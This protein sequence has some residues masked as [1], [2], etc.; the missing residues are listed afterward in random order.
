MVRFRYPMPVRTG[1]AVSAA[2][3][4][5]L[6]AFPQPVD[7]QETEQ[8]ILQELR[9]IRRLLEENLQRGRTAVPQ[10]PSRVEKLEG[11]SV[12]IHGNRFKGS[13]SARVTIV[14]FSDYQCPFCA[15]H[16]KET[17][18]RLEQEFIK[19]GLVKYVYRNFPLDELHPTARAIAIGAEC[20][21]DQQKY[22]DMHDFLFANQTDLGAERIESHAELLGLE[23]ES[24]RSCVIGEAAQH[25]IQRDVEEAK[26]L[27][28]NGTPSF[29]FGLTEENENNIEARY[30]F[31]GALPFSEFKTVIERLLKES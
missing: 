7:A 14:E 23:M 20:A 19:T 18:P 15:R 11:V 29:F 26:N 27:G 25:G 1:L 8:A 13:E 12:G 17:L 22:W 21:G 16:A 24:F 30:L 4:I 2:C 6:A 3:V 10:A 9:E 5:L 28:L 31:R